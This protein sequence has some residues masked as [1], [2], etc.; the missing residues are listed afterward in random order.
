MLQLGKVATVND[1][2][3]QIYR[4]VRKKK[5]DFGEE[6]QTAALTDKNQAEQFCQ[7]AVMHRF[8]KRFGISI[9]WC[10]TLTISNTLSS[11]FL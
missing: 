8:Y 5:P 1:L 3:S 6:V 11:A 4:K 10:K 7:T 9:A 2:R